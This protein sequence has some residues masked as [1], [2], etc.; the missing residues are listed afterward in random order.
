MVAGC[1]VPHADDRGRSAAGAFAA[2]VV[3]R[4]ALRDPLRDRLAGD[5]AAH[6]PCLTGWRAAIFGDDALRLKAGKI[7]LVARGRRIETID[8]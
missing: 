2:G 1:P 7:A 4:A 6:L 3:Q 8:L 5:E